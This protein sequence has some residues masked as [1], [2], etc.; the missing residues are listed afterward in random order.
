MT[1]RRAVLVMLLLD[2]LLLWPFV[3]AH[4]YGHGDL[5]NMHTALYLPAGMEH[6]WGET[7]SVGW[8]WI[9][10]TLRRLF[11]LPSDRFPVVINSLAVLG[12]TASDVFLL[13]AI[14]AV[15][16]VSVALA[17]TVLW[18][19]T[20]EVW[21]V[22]TYAHPWT[23]ALPFFFAGAWI[24]ARTREQESATT[25]TVATAFLWACAIVIRLDLV[26]LLPLA[27]ALAY[28]KA[29]RLLPRLV[30]GS[31]LAVA[32]LGVMQIVAS[33]SGMP[34]TVVSSFLAF[35]QM[36]NVSTNLVVFVLGGGLA[37][38]LLLALV[39]PRYLRDPTRRATVL[40]YGLAVA[41]T[42][43][44]WSTV[45]GGPAR[46]FGPVY[47]LLAF[48]VAAIFASRA[49]G[50][51]F[52]PVAVACLI[53]ANAALA[54][55]ALDIVGTRPRTSVEVGA[56]RWQIERVPLGNVWSNHETEV[57]LNDIETAYASW[58]LACSE[59][60][61]KEVFVRRDA[62]YRLV[63]DALKDLPTIR[64]EETS[65][66]PAFVLGKPEPAMWIVEIPENAGAGWWSKLQAFAAAHG[67]GA[68]VVA[69]R[70][71]VG[72]VGQ[73]TALYGHPPAAESPATIKARPCPRPSS[74]E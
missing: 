12:S 42:I 23:M 21:E 72:L 31:A 4:G 24:T 63:V 13:L 35:A 37:A 3:Y 59:R 61:D 1:R 20:P 58:A 71:P 22:S 73:W 7:F 55:A 41:P 43:V 6:G 40:L 57:R 64:T 66:G 14:S 28:D 60:G 48:A 56:S 26:L 65:L 36:R 51:A 54:E 46:H 50:R 68:S 53:A 17:G 67:A 15:F 11:A 62:S 38:F 5:D 34:R 70:I 18:R 39:L 19:F 8:Y 30:A 47:L 44:G 10:N 49:R 9:A 33:G 16:P 2:V 32:I 45:G 27:F 25:A 29:P 74:P 52:L 69:S